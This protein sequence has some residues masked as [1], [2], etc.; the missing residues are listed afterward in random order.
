[1]SPY[2]ALDYEAFELE[3]AHYRLALADLEQRRPDLEARGDDVNAMLAE[4]QSAWNLYEQA[5]QRTEAA[6]E[7][8]L[9]CMADQVAAEDDLIARVRHGMEHWEKILEEASISNRPEHQVS[10]WEDFESWKRRIRS[11][12]LHTA[13][14]LMTTANYQRVAFEIREILGE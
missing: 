3:R 12:V 10:L 8:H 6:L 1:M 9:Q 7:Y 5:Q 4:L 11:K 2:D 13:S 14:P